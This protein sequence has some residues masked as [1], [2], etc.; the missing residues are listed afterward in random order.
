MAAVERAGVPRQEAPHDR[1]ERHTPR[2]HEE[3]GVIRETRPGNDR[4]VRGRCHGGEP[5]QPGLAV[6]RIGEDAPPLDAPHHDVMEGAGGVEARATGHGRRL[7]K[8]GA[9]VKEKL[10]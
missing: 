5:V 3:V 1:R 4:Q 6:D 8:R 2:P 7:G 9:G 10:K